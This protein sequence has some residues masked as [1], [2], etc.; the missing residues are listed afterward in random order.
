MTN[1][2]RQILIVSQNAMAHAVKIIT[3]NLNGK[4]VELDNV[5]AAAEIITR[6]MIKVSKKLEDELIKPSKKW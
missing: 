2:Q 5:L 6:H 4:K 3:H 1:D